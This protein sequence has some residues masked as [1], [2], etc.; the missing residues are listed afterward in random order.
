MRFAY[1]R[2]T[3]MFKI[4]QKKYG[5]YQNL[6][7]QSVRDWKTNKEDKSMIEENNRCHAKYIRSDGFSHM[8]YIDM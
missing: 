5:N 2:T 1:G 4:Q 7:V 6:Y 8:V 3:K